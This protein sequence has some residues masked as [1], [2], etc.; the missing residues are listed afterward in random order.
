M[1]L[2]KN[3]KFRKMKIII[4]TSKKKIMTSKNLINIIYI[5]KNR[6]TIY[7]NSLKQRMK[8]KK[9]WWICSSDAVINC[10][11]AISSNKMG[12]WLRFTHIAFILSIIIDSCCYKEIIKTNKKKTKIMMKKMKITKSATIIKIQIT[13]KDFNKKITIISLKT[14]KNQI[15]NIIIFNNSNYYNNKNSNKWQSRFTFLWDI[16]KN[17]FTMIFLMQLLTSN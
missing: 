17:S 13:N 11:N 10:S 3:N 5:L 8:N 12:N 7:N 2:L 4:I 1:R 15:I 16:N 6:K 9:N 14:L